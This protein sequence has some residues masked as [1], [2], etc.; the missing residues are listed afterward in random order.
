MITTETLSPIS[1]HGTLGHKF[2]TG[3]SVYQNLAPSLRKPDSEGITKTNQHIV[4]ALSRTSSTV[5]NF[6]EACPCGDSVALL[7]FRFGSRLCG[8]TVLVI[9]TVFCHF[10]EGANPCP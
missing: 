5:V 10:G 1:H 3:L 4:Q 6:G 9:E 2:C 7:S 8:N